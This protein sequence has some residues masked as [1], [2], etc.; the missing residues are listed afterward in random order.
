MLTGE[1]IVHGDFAPENA[2]ARNGPLTGVVDCERRRAGDA[3]LDLIGLAFDIELGAK[4][5][6]QVVAQMDAARR[7]RLPAPVRALYTSIYVV[8]YASWAIGTDMAQEVLALGGR[9]TD[10]F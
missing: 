10:R 5:N 3:N 2:L 4:A 6:A 1:D 7:Q 9:L 8:R